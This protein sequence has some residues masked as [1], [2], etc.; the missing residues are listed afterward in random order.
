MELSSIDLMMDDTGAP[1]VVVGDTQ[2]FSEIPDLLSGVP[3]LAE[4]ANAA[5]AAR[6]VN[7]LAEGSRFDVILDPAAFV[8]AYTARYDAEEETPWEQGR[9]KLRDFGR[10]DLSELA[11]PTVE[12]DQLV[13]Y[14]NDKYLGI[15]YKATLSFANSAIDYQPVPTAV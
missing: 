8:K 2:E 12:G 15:A 6:A 4:P 14:A 9:P 5:E 13:F 10:A 1:M 7:H 11:V 3:A